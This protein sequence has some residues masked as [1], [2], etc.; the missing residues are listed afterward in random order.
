MA[1]ALKRWNG[2]AWITVYS[3]DDF[4]LIGHNHDAS[5]AGA[6]HN[7]DAAYALTSGVSMAGHPG[8]YIKTPDHASLDLTTNICLIAHIAPDDWTPAT[9]DRYLVT[10]QSGTTATN[11]YALVLTTAGALQIQWSTAAPASVGL[12]SPNVSG[13]RAPRSPLWVAVGL[14][15]DLGANTRRYRFWTSDDGLTWTLLSD[16]SFTGSGFGI[17]QTSSPVR[18]GAGGSFDPIDNSGWFEGEF[19]AARIRNGATPTEGSEVARFD[20]KGAQRGRTYIDTYGLP[21]LV[22]ESRPFGIVVRGV[23]VATNPV[24]VA[25]GAAANLTVAMKV[26][27]QLGRRYRVVLFIR[28]IYAVNGSNGVTLYEGTGGTV[29]KGWGDGW[30]EVSRDYGH[31]TFEWVRDGDGLTHNLVARTL[32]QGNVAMNWYTDQGSLFYVEDVGPAL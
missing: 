10:K 5:Y 17:N 6:T 25:A 21:W 16:Q 12:T 22:Q 18:L 20:G 4:A 14:A 31:A 26:V 3:Y 30:V 2:T 27:F 28:A 19:L 32:T 24:I 9:W 1:N 15:I 11:S 29:P 7:H 13:S 23:F 8:E